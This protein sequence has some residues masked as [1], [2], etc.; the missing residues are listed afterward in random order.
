[1]FYV[2]WHTVV[3]SELIYAQN[4]MKYSVPERDSDWNMGFY[5]ET[6]AYENNKR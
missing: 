1:M 3:F 4:I 2:F 5:F 6:S